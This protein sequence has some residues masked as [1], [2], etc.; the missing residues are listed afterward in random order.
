MD[1]ARPDLAR[2]KKI[3]QTL[4]AVTALT[5]VAV[6]TVG[7]SR[8]EPAAPRVDPRHRL[9]RHR[10]A[11]PDGPGG[12]RHGNAGPGAD[13]LAPGHT[14]GSVE[15]IVIRPGALVT[16]ATVIVELSNPELEQTALEARL[17]LAAAE[18]RYQATGRSKSSAIS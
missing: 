13:P 1:I 18:A 9:P 10:A 12:A 5:A 15:R 2:K 14:D 6:V 11:R 17:N 3:R 7:V 8:L 16:P 4:Y